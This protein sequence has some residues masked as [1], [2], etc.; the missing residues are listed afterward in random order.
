[1][2]KLVILSAILLTAS[3][4]HGQIIS[5][6]ADYLSIQQGIDAAGPGDTV[7]VSPGSYKENINYNGKNITVASLFLTTRDT[8]Y[9]SRTIIDGNKAGSVVTFNSEEKATAVLSGFTITHGSSSSGGGIFCCNSSPAWRNIILISNTASYSGG[10]IYCGWNSRPVLENVT[11]TNNA[12]QSGGGMS[13]DGSDPVFD[14][15]HRCHIYLNKAQSGNDLYSG[16]L[17][18]V[19]VDTFTVLKPQAFH[20]FPLSNFTFDILHGKLVQAE[21]DVYVSPGGDNGNSGLSP[22]DPLKTI[23]QAFA[24]IVADSLH[25]RTIHLLK[26][27]YSP[28]ANQ[29]ECPVILPDNI[30]LAGVNSR[31]VTVDA[32]R[33]SSVF[34]IHNTVSTRISGITITGGSS[35][36]GGGICCTNSSPVLEN[37]TITGNTADIGGG[38]FFSGSVP[39]FDSINRCSIFL[40]TAREGNDLYSSSPVE[41][42][43]DTFTVLK[44]KAY[45]AFPISS[46]TFD[47][48]HGKVAQAE[49]DVYV[50]PG[51]DNSNNGLTPADPLKTIHQAFS[52][53]LADSLHPRTIHL[54]DGTYSPSAT[55]ERFPV[56]IPDYISLKGVSS[57]TV[58][59]DAEGEGSVFQ[60]ENN[61]SSLLSGMTITGGSSYQ[62]GG[63]FC[64]NSSPG[65]E[66]LI[67]R[68]NATIASWR[69][70]GSGGGIYCFNSGPVMKNV[71]VTSNTASS[72]GGGISFSGSAPVFDSISRCNIYLNTARH[73]ND[74]YSNSPVKVIVDTFTV[75]KPMAWHACPLFNF[76]FDILHGKVGQAND[77]V[78]VSPGGD[79][80]N[81]GLTHEDPLKTISQAFVIISADSL[82]PRTIHLLKGT[83][84]PSATNEKF[85][86]VLPNYI[87]LEGVNATDAIV[88]AEGT[89]TVFTFYDN[90]SSCL[91]GLTITGGSGESGGGIFCNFSNPSLCNVVISGNSAVNGGGMY[92]TNSRPAMKLVTLTNNTASENGGGIYFGDN[93]RFSFD[94]TCRSNIYFNSAPNGNELYS[95]PHSD[96]IL[97]TFSV[98]H[99]TSLYAQPVSNFSFSILH[100]KLAQ[101]NADVF[102]SPE[103]DNG[104]SG[105]SPGEPL[106]TIGFAIR[107]LLAD[108]LNPGTIHLD[109]GVYS[110]SS[111]TES[112]PVVLPDYVNLKGKN[113]ATTRLDAEGAFFA[114]YFDG[115]TTSA[116]SGLTVSGAS[117][118]GIYFCNSAVA[119]Q[120][121]H[122]SNNSG[123]GFVCTGNNSGSLLQD[124]VISKN[125]SVYGGGMNISGLSPAFRNVVVT[126]NLAEYGG[127]AYCSAAISDIFISN[128]TAV[129]GGGIYVPHYSYPPRAMFVNL[130]INNNVARYGGG[131]YITSSRSSVTRPY[132]K[133]LT[134][135]ENIAAL[136]G[137]IYSEHGGGSA[138]YNTILWSNY[139]HEVYLDNSYFS[140]HSSNVLGGESGIAGIGVNTVRWNNGNLDTDPL[141]ANSGSHPLALSGGSPCIDAGINMLGLYLPACDI[142]GN[143]RC[144]DGNSDGIDM[145]D[146]G[147]YEFAAAAGVE[148]IN[149]QNS[150]LQV[151]TFPNPF[152]STAMIEYNLEKPGDVVLMIF[153]HIGQPIAML[154]SGSQPRGIRQVEWNAEGLP[155]G[156]YYFRLAAGDQ[157]V[158]QRILKL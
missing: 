133:N 11:I 33:T 52:I 45:H 61:F 69:E 4:L 106:K 158:T 91:S 117:G 92:A 142:L 59:V 68:G 49:A 75:L 51:G 124:M 84:S 115:N 112:L 55:N 99:P 87:S 143:H 121:I 137:G 14:R 136:G 32:E 63:I 29:E 147:A 73:G 35:S 24:I 54:L 78:Y 50:S 152:R 132:L 16:S 151:K 100:G 150:A 41:V 144:C 19:T 119:L 108:S 153:N 47:I 43:L 48:L 21:A 141:F 64:S 74:L 128:N 39:V 30:S 70:S 102:V 101:V 1:M 122:V 26:G 56:I 89:G 145:T 85:P 148:E 157:A 53:I 146:L 37:V 77:D 12:A 25:P 60:I 125:T 10:G 118:A 95:I 5:I 129:Y 140:A 127:G 130:V 86:V 82:H 107:I 13:C 15:N 22:A 31:L 155:P 116:I 67:I 46:F 126:D 98:L 42:I 2:K 97:D 62:G 138:I 109:Q 134:I 156:I 18:Q 38:I 80:R 27:T 83:Y 65:L 9:I 72:E 113:K 6:P 34:Q 7:L 135:T 139:P 114:M 79:N 104:N 20:A 44:P 58:I 57:N 90:T 110:P 71:T 111:N 103:G 17:I 40:N 76:S 28:S 154:V 88:D 123:T 81:S 105:K 23:R 93:S 149:V 120:D 36:F 3:A 94:S 66:D 96:V 131:F 8:S